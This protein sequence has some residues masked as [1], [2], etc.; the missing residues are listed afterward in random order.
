M[1]VVVAATGYC[2]TLMVSAKPVILFGKI[3][4]DTYRQR[5]LLRLGMVLLPFHVLL[6]VLFATFVWPLFGV[7]LTG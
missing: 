4:G 2:Q 5:D 6:V 1:L 3:E 7:R